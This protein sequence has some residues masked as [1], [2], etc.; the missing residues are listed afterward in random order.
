ML[1]KLEEDLEKYRTVIITFAD[2]QKIIIYPYAEKIIDE[3]DFIHE[4][5]DFEIVLC[6]CGKLLR[7]IAY[8]SLIKSEYNV[9]RIEV[10]K[11]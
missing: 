5:V 10:L 4:D 8:E 1:S 9:I 2:Y 7:M 11:A 6:E 3:D